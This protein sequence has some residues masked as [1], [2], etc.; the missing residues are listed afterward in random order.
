MKKL[1][2]T[3]IVILLTLYSQAKTIHSEELNIAP[4]SIDKV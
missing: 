4:S 3:P 1:I 2:L